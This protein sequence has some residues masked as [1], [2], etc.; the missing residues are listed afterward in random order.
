[1]ANSRDRVFPQSGQTVGRPPGDKILIVEADPAVSDLIGRQALRSVGY[2]VQIATDAASAINR[3]LQWGPDLILIDLQLPGLSGKDLMVALASQGIQT[4]LIIIAQRGAEADI[5]QT[6]RLGAAD[7]LL[8]PVREAEVI[9]AVNRVLKQVHDRRERE[10]LAQQL[11]QANQELQMRVRELTTI[12]ALGRAM[13]SITDQADLLGKIL[14]AAVRTTQA[15]LGWFLLREDASR[16]FVLAAEHNLPAAAGA[17]LNQPWDDGISSLVAM[18]GEVLAIHGEALRRFKISS[19]GL[20]A[21][22]GPIKVQKVVLG[23]LVMMRQK[24][25]PFGASAQHLLDALADYASISLV[26]ARLVRALEERVRAHQQTAGLAQLVS[27]VNNEALQA[28]K[29]EISGP[30]AKLIAKFDG[31]V[32]EPAVRLRPEQQLQLVEIRDEL[33]RIH[34]V[35]AALTPVQLPRGSFD[36]SRVNMNNL[37]SRSLHRVLPFAQRAGVVFTPV[38]PE[39]PVVVPGDSGLLAQ[40]F[41]GLLGALLKLNSSGSRL[42]IHLDA[43]PDGQAHVVIESKAAVPQEAEKMFDDPGF[44]LSNKDSAGQPAV[45]A[46]PLSLVKEIL[47][48]HNGRIWVST[49]AGKGSDFHI[50]LP[51]AR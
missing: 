2:Q 49:L 10:R 42:A 50:A 43:T 8:L 27:K 4:P 16:P 18:S 30:L 36:R 5:I 7:F 32:K 33:Q 14:D 22:I 48:S 37:I 23:L 38:L 47:V 29:E 25:N 51:L 9:N 40:A 1:M 3:A 31:L 28:V 21:L 35:A 6:F 12:F 39:Q 45:P 44:V 24:A 34:Q 13:T 15:D 19:L 46:I 17:R 26:N 11:Q 20:S 41:E